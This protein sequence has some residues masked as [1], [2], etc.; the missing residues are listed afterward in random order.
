MTKETA[1]IWELVPTKENSEWAVYANGIKTDYVVSVANNKRKMYIL[2]DPKNGIVP[3]YSYDD[4]DEIIEDLAQ[5]WNPPLSSP[6]I[7]RLT[8]K[9]LTP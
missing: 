5:N 4:L 3:S 6:S 9:A 7:D 8:I 1:S 2:H